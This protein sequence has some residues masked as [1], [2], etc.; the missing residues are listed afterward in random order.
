MSN[1]SVWSNIFR[2][3]RSES[4]EAHAIRTVPIFENLSPKEI[5]AVEKR[6]HK[7]SYVTDE[8]IFREKDPGG[9]M[10]IILDG[11]VSIVKNYGGSIEQT[12]ATLK[13]GDFF[14]E[15]A[16]LDESPRTATAISLSDSLILGFYRTDLYELVDRRPK[17][18]VK[19][20]VNLARVVRERLRHSNANAQ[21]L[22]EQLA[23]FKDKSP[24]S[25]A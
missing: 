17:L 20:I 4:E 18:A 1:D 16:L 7:R 9:G 24:E 5:S 25:P 3:R 11:K 13:D 8:E 14:G 21:E 2:N 22:R 10:Y 6:I 19:I 15:I 12:I 23:E